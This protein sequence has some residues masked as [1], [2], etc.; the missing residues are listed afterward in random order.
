MYSWW[1]KNAVL[2]WSGAALAVPD[3]SIH[4]VPSPFQTMFELV[5]LH[6][7]RK[8]YKIN[9]ANHKAVLFSNLTRCLEKIQYAWNKNYPVQMTTL[10]HF[11]D[12]S[13]YILGVSKH[14]CW[15]PCIVF[16]CKAEEPIGV[17][18]KR[19]WDSIMAVFFQKEDSILL[20]ISKCLLPKFFYF[21]LR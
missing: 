11:V 21:L 7:W 18:S 20:Q 8:F 3:H 5:S 2:A 13:L 12:T 9:S 19:N 1:I 4:Q 15:Q 17:Y 16:I 10:F 14:S 6:S